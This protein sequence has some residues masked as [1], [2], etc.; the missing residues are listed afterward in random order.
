M[1]CISPLNLN[2]EKTML[3]KYRTAEQF[4]EIIDSM[5]NGNWSQAA[6]E[7]IE[8]GFWANDLLNELEAHD[9]YDECGPAWCEIVK[10]LV[11]LAELAAETRYKK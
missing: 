3:N 5:T 11:S 9:L 6:K 10:D 8:Y 2:K 4:E 1:G 7:C